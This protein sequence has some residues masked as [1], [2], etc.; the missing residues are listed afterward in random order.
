MWQAFRI[1]IGQARTVV[2]LSGPGPDARLDE[3]ALERE[4]GRLLPRTDELGVGLVDRER[5]A[6]RLPRRMVLTATHDDLPAHLPGESRLVQYGGAHLLVLRGRPEGPRGY[7]ALLDVEF[8][9]VSGRSTG[10]RHRPRPRAHLEGAGRRG[11]GHAREPEDQRLL[12][13]GGDVRDFVVCHSVQVY[14][15]DPE[16]AAA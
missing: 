1:T 12:L 10:P 16:E 6:R 11:G 4:V 7:G 9:Q 13:A 15:L 14:R 2:A 3:D 5:Y 8:K